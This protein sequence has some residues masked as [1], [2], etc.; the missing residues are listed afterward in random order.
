MGLG[1]AFSANCGVHIWVLKPHAPLTSAVLHKGPP[2]PGLPRGTCFTAAPKPLCQ[3]APFSS[4]GPAWENRPHYCGREGR[5]PSFAGDRLCPCLHGSLRA[6][7]LSGPVSLR[8]TQPGFFAAKRDSAL[9][10]KQGLGSCFPP[11][12]PRLHGWHE[13]ISHEL[14]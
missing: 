10:K 5:N 12:R 2:Q 11:P 1:T 6:L 9:L 7:W 3:P 14:S 13:A 4:R 8:G